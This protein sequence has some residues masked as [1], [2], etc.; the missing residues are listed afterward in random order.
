[1]V[2]SQTINGIRNT[3]NDARYGLWTRAKS[4]NCTRVYCPL[5]RKMGKYRAVTER[6]SSFFASA[7]FQLSPAPIY[8]YIFLVSFDNCFPPVIS[9]HFCKKNKKGRLKMI[10]C[11]HFICILSYVKLL[12]KY[13]NAL[14]FVNA[15]VSGIYRF[16]S[17]LCIAMFAYISA[18]FMIFKPQLHTNTPKHI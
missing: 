13:K 2:I 17:F 5:M 16:Y 9:L 1:V 6:A 3:H 15:N 14:S 7:N 18:V 10:Y 11:S 8:F 4:I 12:C